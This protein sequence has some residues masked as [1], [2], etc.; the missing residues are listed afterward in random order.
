MLTCI[1][2]VVC[3]YLPLYFQ[4]T[5]GASAIKSGIDL[6]ALSFI[7]APFAIICGISIGATGHYLVQ[8][9]IGWAFTLVGFGLLSLLHADSPTAAWAGYTV[10]TGIGLGLLYSA[11]NFPILA[12]LRPDQQPQAMGFFNFA[13]SLGQVFGIAI[14]NT[15]LT[16]QLRKRLPAAFLAAHGASAEAAIPFIQ[17]LAE[18]LRAQVKGA[19]A[20]SLRVVWFV[21]LGISG[22]GLVSV[23]AMKSLPLTAETDEK[24]GLEERVKKEVESGR[25]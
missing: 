7:I 23:L 18:P 2:P 9:Y 22:A 14:G 24:W 3:S 21:M 13:R 5:K 11:P 8:N 6:F 17:A 16:N 4:S 20:D 1:L 19:F 10:V 12:P 25:V 15:A